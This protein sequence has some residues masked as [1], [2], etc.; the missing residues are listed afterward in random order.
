MPAE[1]AEP[2]L[3]ERLLI[4]VQVTLAIIDL[5]VLHGNLRLALTHPK[6][7][8]ASTRRAMMLLGRFEQIFHDY[9]LP[10]PPGGWR[11]VEPNGQS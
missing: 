4:P 8:G 6:N 3:Q 11:A 9:G 1:W 5:L 7:R 10:E 2:G